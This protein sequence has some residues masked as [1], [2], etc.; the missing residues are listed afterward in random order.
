MN[1]KADIQIHLIDN[2]D[3]RLIS[4]QL[5]CHAPRLGDEIRVGGA[6]NENYYKVI[7]VVWVYDEP[8]CPFDRVNIGVESTEQ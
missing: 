2:K 1:T 6:G 5:V 4:K 3:D 8:E 7:L